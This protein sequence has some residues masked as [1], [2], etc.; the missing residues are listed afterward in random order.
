MSRQSEA[1]RSRP[2]TSAPHAGVPLLEISRENTPLEAEL[3][4]AVLRVQQSGGFVLGPDV[5][6]LEES[7][8]QLCG[9]KYAIGCASGSDALL[10]ALMA[11]DI[12]PGD[13]VIVPSFTFFATASAVW[14][15]G[16]K[17]IFVDIDPKTFNI[18]A[19]CVAAAI[20]SSTK[21]IIPV[22]LFGQCVDMDSICQLAERHNLV[23]I[24]DAAQAIGAKYHGR[25]AGSMGHVGCFSFYPTKN[26]GGWG[27]G[28][29]LTTSD[30]QLAER[31]RLLRGHGMHP[32]YYHGAVGINSR[33]D[34]IQAAVLN[35]KLAHLSEWT[36]QRQS[37]AECYRELFA[38]ADLGDSIILPTRGTP[39]FH[40]WNQYTI[41]VL[42]GRRDALR[43]HLTDARI[44][45]EIYYPIPLHQQECFRCLGYGEGSL[46]ETERAAQ[47]VLSLP[48]F[49]QLTFEEQRTVVNRIVE[50]FRSEESGHASAVVPT[51]WAS[52][53]LA[54]QMPVES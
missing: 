36:A 1:S 43:S 48:I 46:P 28:G 34:T 29:M 11:I 3:Q 10:L 7:V 12:G 4:A 17:P 8:A 52:S 37:N 54:Q 16:A 13:E 39:Y 40:V 38:A 24:E 41:R 15:L 22:H 47:E 30:E 44:G 19:D 45:S 5:T 49:P 23:V 35:V 31:L 2:D 27:D 32:R 9:A 42:G 18:D 6:R 33:L 53:L 26:L 14:R 20:T 51:A 50:F 25:G 21:A